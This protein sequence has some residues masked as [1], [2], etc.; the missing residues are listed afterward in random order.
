[1]IV[2]DSRRATLASLADV[3]IP[4]GAGMPSASEAGVAGKWLDEFLDARPELGEHLVRILDA[5]DKDK[6]EIFVPRWYR[7][8][9]WVQSLLPGA[10]ANARARTRRRRPRTP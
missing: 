9:A 10:V 6:R 7:P 1:M 4:A 2:S 3:L 5:V 8:A